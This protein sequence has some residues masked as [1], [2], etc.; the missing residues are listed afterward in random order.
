MSTIRRA[1]S[2]ARGEVRARELG[3]EERDVERRVVDD[4]F[5]A[6]REIDELGRDVAEVRPVAQVV[7]RHAVDLGRADVDLALGVEVEVQ[8]AAGGP[9]V[10]ELDAPR[11]R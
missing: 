9:A 8:V 3:V 2:R 5:G 6:A 10:D 7:P 4:P 1:D 11:S